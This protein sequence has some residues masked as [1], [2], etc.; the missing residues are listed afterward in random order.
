MR[1][2]VDAL[3]ILVS[4]GCM[5]NGGT[6]GSSLP[7]WSLDWC[8]TGLS[9]ESCNLENQLCSYRKAACYTT[10]AEIPSCLRTARPVRVLN[11]IISVV[12]T[13]IPQFVLL[14]KFGQA[15][16]KLIV[17]LVR[18]SLVGLFLLSGTW[19]LSNSLNLSEQADRILHH[20]KLCGQPNSTN[21]V[22]YILLS[23]P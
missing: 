9:D 2:C 15:R 20:F 23:I 6:D 10:P 1:L 22:R 3:H 19:L 5:L 21:Q 7:G 16:L 12:P 4:L 8:V 17:T 13:V 11:M 18:R 14:I